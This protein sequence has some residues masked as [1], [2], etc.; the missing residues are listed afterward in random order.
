MYEALLAAIFGLLVGSFLNV[1]IHRWPRDLS[2]VHPR[3]RCPECERQIDWFDNIPVL[4]YLLL[5]GRCRHCRAPISARYPIV[6]LLTAA[7]FFW[8]VW[9]LGPTGSAARYC[10]FAAM[11]IV[12]AFADAETRLLPDEFTLGGALAGLAFACFLAVPDSSFHALADIFN[13]PLGPRALWFGEALLGATLP[14]GSLWLGGIL[15]ERI[16]HKEGLGFGDVKMM[17]MIGAFLGLRGAL[18]TLI[19]GSILGSVTG[20]VYIAITRK[21]MGTYQLPLGTFLAIGGVGVAMFGGPLIAW[22]AST[23]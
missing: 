2:V 3:S 14:A 12:L 13:W 19:A 1:C 23:L 21:D 5:R 15:F 20:L 6:E 22:Y 7:L 9:H 10:V 8:F 17:A 11:L 16:R 4:S 18:L